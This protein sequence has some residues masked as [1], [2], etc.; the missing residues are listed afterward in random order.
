MLFCCQS[1]KQL[2]FCWFCFIDK[3]SV[4]RGGREM[5]NAIFTI[6]HFQV[7]GSLDIKKKKEKTSVCWLFVCCLFLFIPPPLWK[8]P[9]SHPLICLLHLFGSCPYTHAH[10]HK[11]TDRLWG[12]MS[13]VMSRRLTS[14]S[15]SGLPP[16]IC[17]LHAAPHPSTP[18]WGTRSPSR[19][20][21]SSASTEL[22]SF[23]TSPS[24]EPT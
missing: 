2:L 6:S 17:H 20:E 21:L 16:I 10:R 7:S 8:Q 22:H 4:L 5:Q 23:H 11:Q 13:R 19:R 15:R 3:Y 9:L 14:C 12:K 18:S 24:L 1:L